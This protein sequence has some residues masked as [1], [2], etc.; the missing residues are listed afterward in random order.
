MK[1]R[2]TVLSALVLAMQ[3]IAEGHPAQNTDA[4]MTESQKPAPS[5]QHSTENFSFQMRV[6]GG[7][8][9]APAALEVVNGTFL[10]KALVANR[11]VW[12]ILDNRMEGSLIDVDFAKQ[13]NISLGNQRGWLQTPT[14]RLPRYWVEAIPIVVPGQAEFKAPFSAVDL[15]F[16]SKLMGRQISFVMGK[17]YFSN[18][19][20]LISPT[21]HFFQL[22]PS[23]SINPHGNVRKIAL[24]NDRPQIAVSFGGKDYVVTVDLGF[25]G[26]MRLSHEAW[27]KAFGAVPTME[28]RPTAGMDGH[29]S[30]A[31]FAKIPALSSGS[32]V[33]NDLEVSDAPILPADGDGIVGTSFFG[34]SDFVIDT[35]ANSIF[36]ASS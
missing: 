29:V 9:R 18:L 27:N 11:E 17:E 31:K 30:M 24:L 20:F 28:A 2:V 4:P 19:A 12:A 22:A 14:G 33:K 36:I 35:K 5:D 1:L 3:S 26:G 23:G 6:Y 32:Y 8:R 21:H 10:F 34:Q 16:N 13:A 15:S 7:A 25:N